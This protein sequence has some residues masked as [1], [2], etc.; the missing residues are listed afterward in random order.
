MPIAL[1]SL[2]TRLNDGLLAFPAT[3]FTP[4][5]ALDEERYRM[6]FR[7]LAGF[8]PAA[9]FSA[10]GAGEFFSLTLREHEAVVR[11]SVEESSGIPVFAG[12][13]GGIGAALDLSRQSER[14]GADGL[15][16]CPP[17]LVGGEQQGLSAYVET[18]CRSV[19][20]GVVVYN[21]DQ[22]QLLPDTLAR[23]SERCP[24]LIGL[25]DGVGDL[26]T[27]IASRLRLGE[28][29]AFINGMPTAE[30]SAV[31][32]AAIGIRSYSSAV[33]NFAP[34]TALRFYEAFRQRDNVTVDRMLADL[35]LPVGNLRRRG[36]GY[37]VSIVKAW[38]KVMGRSAG[39]VRP[40]LVDLKPDEEELLRSILSV[41]AAPDL[42]ESPDSACEVTRHH[43]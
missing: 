36:R 32:Y 42:L 9:M 34:R 15:L 30:I 40:P 20:I 24:N 8:G 35:Y 4:E 26:E 14:C 3:A 28:R 27:L 39:P 12:V 13:G 25:K 7:Q 22:L 21:R 37:A 29:L 19:G 5:L 10:A 1:D 16:L 18:V 43:G 23:L 2:R 6:L 17:Y 38:L 33:L 11:A 41:H 31:A